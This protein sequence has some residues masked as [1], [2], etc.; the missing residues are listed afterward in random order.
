MNCPSGFC[1]CG[2]T[3]SSC[4]YRIGA[5][6]C[7]IDTGTT[8][9]RITTITLN[10]NAD[11]MPKRQTITVSLG[12]AL[13]LQVTTTLSPLPD[14]QWRKTSA[15]FNS[16]L[17]DWSGIQSP[18]ISSVTAAD[19]GV[20]ECHVPQQRGQGRHAIFRVIVRGCPSNMWGTSTGCQNACPVCYNGG[21]CHDVTG[22]CICA[23]GFSGSICQI[24]NGRN[25]WGMNGTLPCAGA[26]DRHG[27]SCRGRLFCLQDP[28]G[29]SCA[30]GYKGIGC[31]QECDEPNTF[32]PY[33][34][35]TCHCAEGIRC[36]T[37][38]GECND[39]SCT[40]EY[41]PQRCASGWKGRNCQVQTPCP[42]GYYGEICTQSC[43]CRDN[44]A[45]NEE[46]G[47]C[48]DG[49]AD[50]YRGAACD[51]DVTRT[52]VDFGQTGKPNAGQPVTV[53]CETVGNP[54]PTEDDIILLDASNQQIDPFSSIN[55]TG[56]NDYRR[57]NEYVL[58]GD[59]AASGARLT[60]NLRQ[61]D[62]TSLATYL[63]L[64]VYDL[65]FLASAPYIGF[66]DSASIIV[67]WSPWTS[68]QGR[69]DGP[70][71]RIEVH[72]RLRSDD[73]DDTTYAFVE[74]AATNTSTSLII[75]GLE[76][77]TE[78]D[79]V[80]V[81]V[82]EGGGGAGPPSPKVTIGTTCATPTADPIAQLDVLSGTELRLSWQFPPESTWQCRSLQYVQVYQKQSSDSEFPS[83]AIEYESTGTFTT[84]GSLVPCNS[85]D[86]Y[87]TFSNRDG[88]FSPDSSVVSAA[89]A[90][91]APGPVTS[92]QMFPP[93]VG[94]HHQLGVSWSS[95]SA[96]D[97]NCQVDAY[98]IGHSLTRIKACGSS[99]TDPGTVSQRVF[100][101]VTAV[102]LNNLK[103]YSSY[104]VSV[105]A[106][107][108]A[109][110]STVI[111]SS[112]DTSSTVPSFVPTVNVLD[113]DITSNSIRFTWDE[114]SCEDVN[115]PYSSYTYH[116]VLTNLATDDSSTY[117]TNNEV[118]TVIGL[119]PCTMYSFQ[120]AVVNT[121]GIGT[122]SN[123]TEVTTKTVVQSQVSDLSAE[124]VD[125]YPTVLRVRWNLPFGNCPIDH[126]TVSYD[127]YWL[128]RCEYPASNRIVAGRTTDMEYNITSLF[129]N[130]RYKVYVRATTSVGE[131][132]EDVAYVYTAEA[133]PSEPP[134]NVINTTTL[135]R[136]LRFAWQ[137]PSCPGRRGVIVGY[138]YLLIDL[139][140]GGENVTEDTSSSVTDAY[141][142]GLVP[143]TLYSFQV[144][145][146]T[147]AGDGP[148]SDAINLRT[149][150]ADLPFLTSAPYIG[151]TDSASIIVR[152]SPWTSTQG[153]GDGPVLRFEVHY[154]LRSDDVDDTTY[155][156]VE[157]AA[158]NTSTSLIIRGLEVDT[159]YD[160]VVVVVREGDGGA[161]P[162]SPKVTI[163]TTCA[164][165]T[166]DP[167]A[168]LDVVSGTELRL[169]WQ[170]PPESTWQCRS[171]QYVQV[172]QKQSSESEFPSN[173]IQYEATGSF[174]TLGSLVPCT[175]YDVYVTFSNRD[176]FF[177]PDSSIVSAATATT[178]PGPVTSLQMFPPT[179]GS[180]HQLEVSWSSPSSASSADNNC[181]VDAYI[182]SHSLTRIKAC[183]S[184]GTDLGTVSQRVFSVV[185]AVSLNNLK[186]YSSYR[187]SVVAVNSAGNST[188][189]TSSADTSSTVPSFVPTVNVLDSDITSNSI[190]FT[191]DEVSCEDV[192]GPYSSY[193]YRPVLTNLATDDSSTYSTN[194]EVKTV[195]GLTPCTMYS[196]QV[197]V[198][199]TVGIGTYSN[200]TEVTT[201]TVVQSQVSDL[202]A[203]AVDGY[204]TVLRVRWNLPSG[205]CPIDHYTV[206][207][208]L[209]WLLRCEYP[210][211][212]R[213]VAGRTT[214]ME[215]NITSLFPNSRYKVYVRATTSVGEGV[216]DVEY[217]YTAEAAP[218]EPPQNVINTATL[219]RSLR[220]AWQSPPCLGRRGDIVGYTYLLIDLER[221]AE[222][223]TADTSSSV[224]DAYIGGLVPYTLYSFQ[225]LARTA[226]GDGPYSD[227]INVRTDQAEPPEI[228][229]VTTPSGNATSTTVQWPRPDHNGI[230][231]AYYVVY[232]IVS[233]G[234]QST[235]QV[236]EGLN[237]TAI[238]VEL[239]GL[240]TD[241]NYSIQIQAETIVK[242]G[243]LSEPIYRIIHYRD[244]VPPEFTANSCPSPI[245]RVAELRSMVTMVTW[246]DP[247]ATDN[248]APIVQCTPASGTNF[249]I[250]LTPVTCTATDAAGNEATLDCAFNVTVTDFNECAAWLGAYGRHD[251]VHSECNNTDGG[252]TC[253]CHNG[254]SKPNMNDH[255]CTDTTPPVFLANTCRSPGS[256]VAYPR[257]M[258]STSVTWT[259][260]TATDT[261]GIA[262]TV[263]CTPSTNHA[264][265]IGDTAV[266]CTA[267]DA[268]GNMALINCLFTVTVI[269]FDECSAV[270]NGDNCDTHADCTN[271][272]GGFLC[273]CIVG[274][275]GNGVTCTDVPSAPV[276]VLLDDEG[277]TCVVTWDPPEQENG[278]LDIISYKIFRNAYL[279]PDSG[280]KH[281][282]EISDLAVS[283]FVVTDATPRLYAVNKMDLPAY[284][285]Y[286]FQISASTSNSEG[287]TS[288]ETE[289]TCDSPRRVPANL[290]PL[291]LSDISRY[292]I[293]ETTIKLRIAP[294]NQRN[295]PVSCVEVTVIRLNDDEGIEGKDPDI[296]YHPD[297]LRSYD[298]AQQSTGLPYVAMVFKGNDLSKSAEIEIGSGGESSCGGSRR[299]KRQTPP[300]HTGENGPL[301]PHTKYTAFIRAYVLLDNQREDYVTSPRLQPVWTDPSGTRN[302]AVIAVV[303]VVSTTLII[304]LIACGVRVGIRRKKRR[305]KHRLLKMTAMEMGRIDYKVTPPES[306]IATADYKDLGLPS[307]ALRWE[308]LWENLVVDDKVLGR[309]N[310]GEVR[311]GTVIIGGMMTKTAIQV[312]KGDASKTDREDFMEEFRTM[313][314]IGYHPNVVSLL[315]ACQHEDVMFVAL[316]HL[317]N[318]DLRT[319]LRKARTQSESDEGALSSDQLI[320]FA[321]DVAKGMKHLSTSGVIHR[322]LAS[323]NILLG[324]QLVAKVSDF[325]L[326][327]GQD[328]YVQT[329]M[330]RISTRWLA[331]ESLLDRTYTTQS[332]VWSFGI[333]LWEIAS[334]GGTPYPTIATKSLADQLKEGY[335]LTKPANCDDQMYSLMLRCWEED[336]SNRPSFSDLIRILSKMDENKTEQ[337][338]MAIDR[339]LSENFSV[340]RPELDDN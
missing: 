145:A 224:M 156:F 128:L 143:Y 212:N 247:T 228:T 308:I 188:V 332:D 179:V 302:I 28:F 249:T 152:W 140:R 22:Q 263:T 244:T 93:T 229:S 199:N 35:Q 242:R 202:S 210:A 284:T 111:T 131:G 121:V 101:V 49:C 206:S 84:L 281:L 107:N 214:D 76:V 296:L 58:T 117:S 195:I 336:P 161:G 283:D 89:T 110:N 187:V 124:A 299:K 252:F 95:P 324:E 261:T 153:R 298:E 317:P 174:T 222:N 20:Y 139:E 265:R 305:N 162:P 200:A 259:T 23:P 245:S 141:I 328:I 192:N 70:V 4:L 91:T 160:F 183:G 155:E 326:S 184:S 54:L 216:E 105:V 307:W 211:S 194:N 147:A 314:N 38:T 331:I 3:G 129:P 312:L 12:E 278:T 34:T 288:T 8:V 157:T 10:S 303:S 335:R 186:P 96:A 72:Y 103:P 270:T 313:T 327:R 170:F 24:A 273:S 321:L 137:S 87:V 269:D 79:F 337:K 333:L 5:F 205:N 225:V 19:A 73:V 97:N 290:L 123:A 134:Q 80:V 198:V 309:G 340:I 203:E 172:Y 330:P 196:F 92:L 294:V 218:S 237:D 47:D 77:D 297:L 82:R 248:V 136:S 108:S 64:D 138:T 127:L 59:D 83:N 146:R 185:T 301:I 135:K 29:C 181:P 255:T 61:L 236:T 173:A 102:S 130:S 142:D 48:I 287:P 16:W 81:V 122:Y 41:C 201:E 53:Y 221:G 311:L 310:F 25:G 18:T 306:E 239:T 260:P 65:P 250:G 164:T 279:Y 15:E 193:T 168:Q 300:S 99:G 151:F 285:R 150:Q 227:A 144:L 329:S 334:I 232:G 282:G 289:I 30:A 230:I 325:G 165:P 246:T 154:R 71:L 120:V 316:E 45:C 62:S 266:T 90:T 322:D 31:D 119:T 6:Y 75:R 190:R 88:F 1:S 63:T 148:Y 178:A 26:E 133:A 234:N 219:K 231:I 36:L 51:Q 39:P 98:I 207:Y 158:T 213:I 52:I 55:S 43:N 44:Q 209:Y 272:D 338:Y 315:G 241:S 293:T 277:D 163:G 166:A 66:T 167:I 176:G 33:C 286:R 175:S 235:L 220:F 27:A 112:A 208:D 94:S 238:E 320:K 106:V 126:Y 197:A 11:I 7:Q 115:G 217:V 132:V 304:A 177:S 78:Y 233:Q 191:W 42:L 118:K 318:G 67:R 159:E 280:S 319:Y 291:V 68:T 116:P 125:G 57:I 50:G 149:D 9:E 14:W 171:L 85:Y 86:V 100:S 182:I 243:P 169:S 323:R 2:G 17:N 292:Q 114:V 275:I 204:P 253:I 240:V 109:G 37:D 274:Y 215:Y 254:F 271:I 257:S 180:H 113:S 339:A 267:R 276:K 74:T 268:A 295:G 223:V 21:M 251:C 264:F 46:S 40:D 60:C 189:I 258:T 32:G 262:P 13:T 226:A 69:G 104:R 256:K 56:F